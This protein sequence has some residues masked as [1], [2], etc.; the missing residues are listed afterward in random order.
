VLPDKEYWGTAE[1]LGPFLDGIEYSIVAQ[2]SAQ[3]TAMQAG[4]IDLIHYTIPPPAGE[5]I[6]LKDV[7]SV[8]ILQLPSHSFTEFRLNRGKPPFDNADLLKAVGYALDRQAILVGNHG[9]FGKPAGGPINPATWAFNPDFKGFNLPKGERDAKVKEHL[10]KG[11]MPN[12][13][14]FTF[15]LAGSTERAETVKQMVKPYGI[16]VT[17]EVLPAT[18]GTQY[19]YDGDFQATPSYTPQYSPDPDSI[20]RPNFHSE[21]QF[22]YH[23]F[24]SAEFDALLDRAATETDQAKRKSMYWQAQDMIFDLGIPRIPNIHVDILVPVKKKVKNLAVGWDTFVRIG[25]VWLDS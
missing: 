24:K 22:N 9:G 7:S 16:D 25:G 18:A 4:E 20:F 23:R 8:T 3:V 5:I 19:L 12:G 6:Q 2:T 15:K 1:G 11:G 21:G 14:P 10:Q 13:F 17:I